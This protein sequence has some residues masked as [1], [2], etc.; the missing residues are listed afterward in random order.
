MKKII[1]T[2]VLSLGFA[3]LLAGCASTNGISLA[4]NSPAAIVSIN[5]TN[6]VAWQEKET[7]DND[8][9]YSTDGVLNSLV[10]KVISGK[11]PEISTAI[12]RL[13]YAD[14]SFRQIVPEITGLKIL[15]K[16]EVVDSD[17]YKYTRGS[18]YNAL[19]DTA[20]A[21]DYKDM[22]VIGAKKARMLMEQIGANSL[23][24]MDFTF[25][26][27]LAKGNRSE[28]QLTAFVRM[29]IKVLNNRG[30]EIINKEYTA[31]GADTTIIS[32]G[33]YKKDDLIEIIK[34]TTD[35]L[36]TKFAVEYSNGAA[37][38]SEDVSVSEKAELKEDSNTSGAATVAP[39][40]LGA[41][42]SKTEVKNNELTAE[43]AVEQRAEETARNLLKMNME[44]EKIAEATGVPL[45]RI[46]EMKQEM[47]GQAQ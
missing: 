2:T 3:A 44:S 4:D 32:G 38:I 26:K 31:Q 22:S 27:I 23:V 16:K 42:K 9:E 12:D 19:S 14:D 33:Y 35:D 43:K 41:P 8:E 6:L 11:D 18:F 15:D 24:S 47:E 7:N 29:K 21:T 28:G 45:E 39:V 30:K 20:K 13:D 10:N 25:R 17:A 37:G 34:K 1:T 46:N 36:I 5:G 40:K